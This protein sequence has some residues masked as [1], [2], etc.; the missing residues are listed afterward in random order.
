MKITIKK[1]DPTV[2]KVPYDKTY[3]VPHV[4][5]MTALQAIIY[6][7]ENHEPLAYDYSCRGRSCGRCAMMVDGV[8]CTACTTA[9]ADTN[10][11][12]EPL[13]GFPVIRDLVV[14]KKVVQDSLSHLARRINSREVTWEDILKP[15]DMHTFVR[16]DA[17]ERCARCLVCHTSCDVMHLIPDK[18]A[19]PTAMTTIAM[20]FF[21]PYDEGD[22]VLQAVNLG[23][24]NCTMCGIC[25]E[26]CPALEIKHLEMW[27]ELRDAAAARGLTEPMGSALKMGDRR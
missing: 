1:F 5:Y 7:D 17:T 3:D 18:F 26:V 20:R 21:D 8:A 14:D 15:V 6:I 11:T 2:D 13:K 25:D 22:R 19:G 23:L 9:I 12:I 10:H 4:Q 24:W 27:Q 16:L